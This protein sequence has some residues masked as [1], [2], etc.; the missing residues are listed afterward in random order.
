MCEWKLLDVQLHLALSRMSYMIINMYWD[1]EHITRL[2]SLFVIIVIIIFLSIY[3]I[4]FIFI[5][6]III[7]YLGGGGVELGWLLT[8]LVERC[9]QVLI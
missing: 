5:I 9:V 1:V 6:I 8:S 2:L 7:F 4:S 3:F